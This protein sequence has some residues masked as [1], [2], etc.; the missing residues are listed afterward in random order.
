MAPPRLSLCAGALL[1]IAGGAAWGG[2]VPPNL[3]PPLADT[4]LAALRGGTDTTHV[5]NDMR[6]HGTTSDNS[7]VHVRTGNNTITDGALGD[8]MGIPVVI[9]NTGANVLIQNA[10]IVNVQMR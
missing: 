10:V 3:G 8:V 4:E 1:A 5:F 9:Q 2:E 7:A 6:L